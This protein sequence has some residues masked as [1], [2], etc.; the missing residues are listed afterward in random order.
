MVDPN[1]QFQSP[2]PYLNPNLM[3]MHQFGQQNPMFPPSM[4]QF[5]QQQYGMPPPSP[6]FPLMSPTLPQQQQNRASSTS[7]RTSPYPTPNAQSRNVRPTP[8]QRSASIATPQ[9]SSAN[10]KQRPNSSRMTTEEERRN[11]LP[12]KVSTSPVTTPTLHDSVSP[13]PHSLSASP[14]MSDPTFAQPHSYPGAFHGAMATQAMNNPYAPLTPSLPMNTQQILSDGM[15][16]FM[17]DTK[18]P[19]LKPNASGM[20]Q[21]MYNYNP[22]GTSSKNLKK[23]GLDEITTS[24]G[25]D[26]TLMPTA[27]DTSVSEPGKASYFN[28]PYSASSNYMGSAVTDPG[29]NFGFQDDEFGFDMFKSSQS[30]PHPSPAEFNSFVHDDMFNDQQFAF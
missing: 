5:N 20:N 26:Q 4:Y 29:Y 18:Y 2:G 22:N 30:S 14:L 1:S 25:L 11:S 21:P 24:T 7:H 16:G 6:S 3:Q 15:F 9:E 28:N 12:P 8:H 27:L 13:R 17:D 23:R 19:M 10:K